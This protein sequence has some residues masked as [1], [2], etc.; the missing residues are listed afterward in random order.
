MSFEEKY[1]HYKNSRNLDVS[2]DY[3]NKTVERVSDKI[4]SP[5]R[6]ARP[7]IWGFS[8][9]AAIATVFIFLIYPMAFRQTPNKPIT[10]QPT[11]TKQNIAQSPNDIQAKDSGAL[12]SVPVKKETVSNDELDQEAVIEYLID[13]GYEEI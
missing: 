5:R 6:N 9:T 7:F 2:E 1:K 13:E 10:K 3:I 8:A 4:S 11:E 12:A